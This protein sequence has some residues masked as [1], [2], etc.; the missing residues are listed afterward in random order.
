MYFEG[1]VRSLDKIIRMVFMK[2]KLEKIMWKK[3]GVYQFI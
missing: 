3:W 2:I 1:F